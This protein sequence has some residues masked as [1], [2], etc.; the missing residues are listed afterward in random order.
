MLGTLVGFAMAAT[1]GGPA[2][3]NRYTVGLRNRLKGF[4]DEGL[5]I[6]PTQAAQATAQGRNGNGLNVVLLHD[7]DQILETSLNIFD[8]TF[9]AP[10]GAWWGS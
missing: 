10:V 9:V 2:G 7:L 6:V 4:D 8:A 5:N 1:G 3:S